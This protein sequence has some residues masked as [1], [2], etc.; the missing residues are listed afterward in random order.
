MLLALT[1]S[2]SI[3][4]A[5]WGCSTQNAAS[6]SAEPSNAAPMSLQQACIDEG[7]RI[8]NISSDQV[9]AI[10]STEFG[11]GTWDIT[12]MIGARQGICS[13]DSEGKILSIRGE[14]GTL[15]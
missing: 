10:N 6:R 4:V 5:Q 9:Y 13:V 3:A 2:L 11:N 8:V 15:Y 12:L 1:A 7:A 14:G